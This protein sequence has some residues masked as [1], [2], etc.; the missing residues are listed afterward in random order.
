MVVEA[1]RRF[2]E[3]GFYSIEQVSNEGDFRTQLALRGLGNLQEMRIGSRGLFM[4]I[5]NAAGYLMT[6]G[7]VQGLFE[8]I[9][10]VD[11]KV[12]WALSES[13]NLEVE[14]NPLG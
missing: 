6:I 10:D 12:E 13:G 1:Q 4:H 9:F 11:S 7:M 5:D 3:T 8:M 2:T 14:V